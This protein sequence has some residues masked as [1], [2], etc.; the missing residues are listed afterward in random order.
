MGTATVT[1]ITG[2]TK[3]VAEIIL[4]TTNR[5]EETAQ[6]TSVVNIG[7]KFSTQALQAE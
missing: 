3:P 5:E 4:G 7:S 1:T 2:K 6:T